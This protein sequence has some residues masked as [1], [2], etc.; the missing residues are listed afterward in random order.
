M[1]RLKSARSKSPSA[2]KF[3][4]RQMQRERSR[5]DIEI[6]HVLEHWPTLYYM[7]AVR[8]PWPTGNIWPAAH[9]RVA[10]MA[11]STKKSAQIS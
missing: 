10:R 5:H 7:P 6:E 3:N 11:V 2:K 9:F 8:K 4:R 1:I